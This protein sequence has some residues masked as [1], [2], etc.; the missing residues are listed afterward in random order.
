M[1]A[2]SQTTFQMQF[3]K[4]NVW[5][6]IKISLRFVPKELIDKNSALV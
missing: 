6:V 1:A 2:V 4:E 3:L 5:I